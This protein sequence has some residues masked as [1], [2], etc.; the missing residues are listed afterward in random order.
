MSNGCPMLSDTFQFLLELLKPRL[1]KQS[2]KFGRHS[3]SPEKQLFI[4]IWTM[5]TPNSYRCVSDRFDVGKATW[6]SVQRVVNALYANVTKFIRRPT[7]EEA[8]ETIEIIQRNHT[9]SGVIDVIDGTHK[10]TAPKDHNE[11]YVNRKGFHSIQLQV[12]C[13]ADLKFIDCYAGQVG[14]V[15]DMS[16]DYRILKACITIKIFHI[17]IYWAMQH[18]VSYLMVP[19]KDNGHLPER[20]VYIN[21]RLSTVRIKME[22]SIALL[23]SDFQSLLDT[24]PMQ[25]TDLIPKY[26]IAYC[27]LHNICLLK[28][29]IIVIPIIVN[30]ESNITE[31][32]N[33]LESNTSQREDIDKRNCMY[34]IAQYNC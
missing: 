33:T 27:I 11:S 9:F 17:V 3:I 25:R 1:G 18:T 34:A 14:S 12:I 4:A 26:I 8:E 13:D 22:R 29:D 6:H 5:A 32:S 2:S 16:L 30:N 20:Q 19:F 15:H 10:L 28:N 31:Q 23:K 7:R 21:R 24:L